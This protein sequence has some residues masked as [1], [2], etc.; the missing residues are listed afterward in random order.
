MKMDPMIKE[1]LHGWKERFEQEVGDAQDH[2]VAI[3]QYATE[4]IA[5]RNASI[6]DTIRYKMEQ[7]I[8]RERPEDAKSYTL[9]MA[10]G[11]MQMLNYWSIL[12]QQEETTAKLTEIEKCVLREVAAHPNITP[13]QIMH[14]LQLENRQH[15][16]NLLRKLRAKELVQYWEAGKYH[17]YSVTSLGQRVAEMLIGQ[18]EQAAALDRKQ[19][20]REWAEQISQRDFQPIY[21]RMALIEIKTSDSLLDYTPLSLDW[22]HEI[23]DSPFFEYRDEEELG[24]EIVA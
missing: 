22:S 19:V 15:M 24:E 8:G 12:H 7:S 23:A 10:H 16:S 4:A 13:S 3:M 21:K 11:F 14:H 6:L 18:E 17:Y 2:L 9:G 5:A 20:I 1:S